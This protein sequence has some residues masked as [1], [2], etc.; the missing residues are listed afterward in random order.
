MKIIKSLGVVALLLLAGVAISSFVSKDADSPD[1][2]AA[3]MP[4]WEMSKTHTLEVLD[5]M[6]EDKFTYT[7]TPESKSFASQM[8][9]IGYTLHFFN[10]RM[11]QGQEIQYAEPDAA[12][13]TKAEIREMVAKNFDEIMATVSGLTEENLSIT[14][15]FGPGKEMSVAQA[16]LFAHDHTTNHRAKAN[17]YLRMNDITPPNYKFM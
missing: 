10:V 5:A 13:M 9:H 14:F 11:L 7:P 8:V 6:P 3:T 2:V 1:M 12:T 16:I 17:L 4:L 15:P